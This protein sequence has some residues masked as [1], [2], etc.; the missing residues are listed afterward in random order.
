MYSVT[1][2]LMRQ[3]LVNKHIKSFSFCSSEVKRRSK[4]IISTKRLHKYGPPMKQITLMA[5]HQLAVALSMLFIFCCGCYNAEKSSNFAKKAGL[6]RDPVLQTSTSGLTSKLVR[7]TSSAPDYSSDPVRRTSSASGLSRGQRRWRRERPLCG[8][9][10]RCS[11]GGGNNT[12]AYCNNFDGS[13][14]M[15]CIPHFPP[16][17]VSLYFWG[18]KITHEQLMKPD[19]FRNVSQLSSL[20]LSNCS[21]HHVQK[22]MF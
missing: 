12:E 4:L 22:E 1:L 19:F 14:T 3:V 7:R 17:I 10:L 15:T 11:V 2:F 16:A 20:T 9:Y 5:L 8:E 21:I 18:F 6:S 13:I